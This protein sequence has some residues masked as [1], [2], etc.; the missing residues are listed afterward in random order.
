MPPSYPRRVAATV[1]ETDWELISA[2]LGQIWPSICNAT[3]GYLADFPQRAAD[4]DRLRVYVRPDSG[5][6]YFAVSAS[7]PRNFYGEVACVAIPHVE[8]EYYKLP[9]SENEFEQAHQS[10]MLRLMSAVKTSCSFELSPLP[11]TFVEYD[12]LETE[13]SVHEIDR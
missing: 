12:D 8:S 6:L 11:L 3:R 9:R 10:L 5:S 2:S 4:A 13:R 1:S 7:P